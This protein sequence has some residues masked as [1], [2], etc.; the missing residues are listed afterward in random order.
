MSTGIELPVDAGA[1]A[2]DEE[3]D[4]DSDTMVQGCA[5]FKLENMMCMN[6]IP[7]PTLKLAYSDELFVYFTSRKT[8]G[9]AISP[10]KGDEPTEAE[11]PTKEPDESDGEAT[12]AMDSQETNKRKR[13][14]HG[15]SHWLD[16]LFGRSWKRLLPYDNILA[17]I[18]QGVLFERGPRNHCSRKMLKME[19]LSATLDITV[20]GQRLHVGNTL[21]PIQVKSSVKQVSFVIQ[22]LARDLN[23]AKAARLPSVPPS[24]APSAAADAS[25]ESPP[26]STPGT[27]GTPGDTDDT[28]QHQPN[29]AQWHARALAAKANDVF[30]REHDSVINKEELPTDV[31]WAKSKRVYIV[32]KLREGITSKTT[33]PQHFRVFKKA[34]CVT[35]EINEQRERALHFHATGQVAPRVVATA[36]AEVS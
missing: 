36:A 34:P 17:A 1:A 9:K 5:E 2:A 19:V 4:S 23:A 35:T 33:L 24:S 22:Q 30:E 12:T 29:Q 20:R 3:H 31:W 8:K 27:P 11:H 10:T 25:S 28:E 26:T 32:Q 7:I 13:E 6:G 16:S 21:W 15:T 14:T 18:Q